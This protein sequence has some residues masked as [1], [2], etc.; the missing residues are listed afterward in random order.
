MVRDISYLK[1]DLTYSFAKDYMA[2]IFMS[3]EIILKDVLAWGIIGTLST[4]PMVDQSLSY[5][6]N[7][8]F[9]SSQ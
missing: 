2:F 8:Y 4:K 5:V 3:S 1:I 9:L 6:V 7:M